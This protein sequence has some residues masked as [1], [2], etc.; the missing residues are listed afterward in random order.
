MGIRTEFPTW[1]LSDKERTDVADIIVEKCG[2][3]EDAAIHLAYNMCFRNELT[4]RLEDIP[5]QYA[6]PICMEPLVERSSDG[7]VDASNIWFAPNRKTEHWNKKAC[8][9]LCCRPCMS[10]WAETAIND[11]RLTIKCPTAGCA[12]CLWDQDLK[13]LVSQAAFA[14]H[15]EHKNRDYLKHLRSTMKNNDALTNWLKSNARPC[16]DCHVIVSRYEGCNSMMCICGTRFCYKCGYKKC[17][18]RNGRNRDDIWHPP[19]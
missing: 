10:Q 19:K 6:C 12:Y 4:S 3:S 15:Q 9:H 1:S 16:P 14:K 7:S 2:A 11:Q 5:D 17:E 18:C 13:V 8:G